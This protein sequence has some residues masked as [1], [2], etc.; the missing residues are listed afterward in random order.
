MTCEYTGMFGA[1]HTLQHTVCKTPPVYVHV[2]HTA[3][4]EKHINAAS[5]TENRKRVISF[6][7]T[8]VICNADDNKTTKLQRKNKFLSVHMCFLIRESQLC[9]NLLFTASLSVKHHFGF[10]SE[11]EC[12]CARDQPRPCWAA[13]LGAWWRWV[14]WEGGKPEGQLGWQ[15]VMKHGGGFGRQGNTSAV[16]QINYAPSM[17]TWWRCTHTNTGTASLNL[18]LDFTEGTLPLSV[19]CLYLYLILQLSEGTLC[20]SPPDQIRL[21][22]ECWGTQGT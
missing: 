21:V 2:P 19:L 15:W 5:S 13:C 8:G 4:I 6:Y 3:E 9:R 17:W 14:W 7:L 20:L 10:V 22:W 12:Q 16:I 1:C 11:H 18:P